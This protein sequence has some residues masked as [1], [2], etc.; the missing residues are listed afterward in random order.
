MGNDR[1]VLVVWYA[2]ALLNLLVHLV[3][4]YGLAFSCDLR[5]RVR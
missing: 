4:W 3:H 1:K 2:Y 5:C